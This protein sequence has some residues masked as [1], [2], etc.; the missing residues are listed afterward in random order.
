LRDFQV[1]LETHHFSTRKEIDNGLYTFKNLFHDIIIPLQG[2]T[3]I[4]YTKDGYSDYLK[5]VERN[6]R[7]NQV[8]RFELQPEHPSIKDHFKY[9]TSPFGEVVRGRDSL[10]QDPTKPVITFNRLNELPNY[11]REPYVTH[12]GNKNVPMFL[13]AKYYTI[14]F[15]PWMENKEEK[16][17]I[18]HL[19]QYLYQQ[20][21][22][23]D[24]FFEDFD[25]YAQ[26]VYEYPPRVNSNLD[27]IISYFLDHD[28]MGVTRKQYDL[29][30]KSFLDKIQKILLDRSVCSYTLNQIPLDGL[31][32]IRLNGVLKNMVYFMI[33]EK[34]ENV[35]FDHTSIHQ[36]APGF[37]N[38]QIIQ[39]ISGLELDLGSELYAEHGSYLYAYINAINGNRTSKHK[40]L[41][42]RYLEFDSN[43]LSNFEPQN[44]SSI[45]NKKAAK[46]NSPD[47]GA[48]TDTEIVFVA[49][50]YVYKKK[51]FFQEVHPKNRTT[52]S[53]RRIKGTVRGK[54]IKI[55]KIFERR[56]KI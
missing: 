37:G 12:S 25:I 39:H 18:L 26:S 17:R 8:K 33:F 5:H 46:L 6:M 35:V 52:S 1:S 7:Y 55:F 3:K 15:L 43:D 42:G 47:T 40:K 4:F 54:G 2:E 38:D 32:L 50:L 34:E 11:K 23:K 9:I 21:R 44:E 20:Q 51:A 30:T 45:F 49:R 29:F 27:R 22:F 13:D 16:E 14:E 36:I 31:Y 24:K 48:T 19:T 41:K 56:I 10:V 53:S 28:G